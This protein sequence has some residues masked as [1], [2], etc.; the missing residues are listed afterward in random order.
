MGIMR[1]VLAPLVT[2]SPA[3]VFEPKSPAPPVV[4]NPQNVIAAAQLCNCNS[5]VT[6]PTFV[7]LWAHSDS[8]VQYLASLK[9]VVV[10][11]GPLSV[12]NGN[13]LVAA[14][15]KL[16]SAYG[17]TETGPVAHV[18]DGIYASPSDPNVKTV[19]DWQWQTF[20]PSTQPRWVSQG[21]GT[22]ELQFLSS[23][24]SSRPATLINQALKTFLM[25]QAMRRQ[26]FLYLIRANKDYGKWEKIVPIPQER[27]IASHPL[28]A[29]AVMFGRAKL[30][31]GVLVDP[32]PQHLVDPNDMVAVSKYIDEIW[33]CIEQANAG[34]PA[35]A[36]IFREMVILTEASRPLPR[37]AKG[38]VVRKLA[39]DLYA[40]KF[41]N[42]YDIM[43]SNTS[44]MPDSSPHT[45]NADAIKAW[46]LSLSATINNGVAIQPSVDIFEQGFDSLHATF[47]RN[48][49]VNALR[50]SDNEGVQAA[51]TRID[52]NIVYAYPIVTKLAEALASIVSAKDVS[53]HSGLQTKSIDRWVADYSANLV[54]PRATG[55][56]PRTE[57][58]VF[59][60]GSTGSLGSHILALLLANPAVSKVF[61]FNR[62]SQI[63]FD[64]HVSSFEDRGL[65]TALLNGGKHVPLFGDLSHDDFDL[66]TEILKDLASNLT[67]IVHNAWRVDFNHSLD[68]FQSQIAGTRKLLNFCSALERPVRMLYTSSIGLAHSWPAQKGAVL[69]S[70][71]SDLTLSIDSGYSASKFVVE[72]MLN[73][74]HCKGFEVT[75][76][77][78]GQV[79]GST[80]SGAWNT[81]EWVPILIKSVLALNCLPDLDGPVTWIPV[82]VVAQVFVDLLFSPKR[83]PP[84]INV[85]HPRPITWKQIANYLSGALRTPLPLVPLQTWLQ[86]VE[87]FAENAKAHDVQRIPAIKLLGFFRKS[88]LQGPVSFDTTKAES[89]SQSIRTLEPLGE[90]DVQNWVEY[91]KK[92]HFL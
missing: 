7:E 80:V 15:V 79:C 75:S 43:Q 59:L 35:F 20:P 33:P 87:A 91:W 73:T 39:L 14:G 27:H 16:V 36:R 83:L 5:I 77:R 24:T 29:D 40:E 44:L 31:A 2:A 26:T 22:Y 67:H 63:Q 45:W 30:Q 61:T 57:M 23:R 52:Q 68:S 76:L 69:E 56:V 86:Q 41:K 18:F 60:T 11:G 8:T 70:V 53:H 88:T 17:T 42:L 49:I 3:A 13:K 74:A 12:E 32:A 4:P 48:H 28:V 54:A 84:V 10:G 1:H 51:A 66:P 21:D 34:A 90:E 37:A 47:M 78:V 50:I 89:L 6:V 25:C 92:K 38:N 82:D 58:V 55:E 81:N 62:P 46:L 64:R 19:Q 72:Q 85:V 65:S 71:L 9:I